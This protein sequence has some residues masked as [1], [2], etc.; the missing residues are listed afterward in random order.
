VRNNNKIQ[1][2]LNHNIQAADFAATL[3][4]RTLILNA[5]FEI[6]FL[7]LSHRQST[8]HSSSGLARELAPWGLTGFIFQGGINKI[9]L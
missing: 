9:T 2:N 6:A 3:L 5:A 8:L 7:S 1:G 4:P